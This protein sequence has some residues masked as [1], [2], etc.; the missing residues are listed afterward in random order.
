[1][2]NNIKVG[3]R[4]YMLV[5]FLLVSMCLT[6][7][8]GLNA[9][10]QA[11]KGLDTVYQDRVVPLKDLKIIADMY[12]V[13][14]VDTS[15]KIRNGNLSWELGEE[16]VREAAEVIR[17]KWQ[18]YLATFLVPQEKKLIEEA[19]PLMEKAD[20]AVARLSKMITEKDKETL[21]QF[22]IQELYPVIDPIS[23]KFS[24]LVDVQLQVAKE[25]Y[26]RATSAYNR[27]LLLSIGIIV[28]AVAS[29]IFF[30]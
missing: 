22:T 3:T 9:A 23:G 13:N 26:D 12:A 20:Q 29:G 30:G 28:A 21:T 11:A 14:I 16:N 24:E 19:T 1:M 7:L 15:H 2:I 10:K 17:K 18:A 25:E 8:I 27:S 6:C 4:L 5:A